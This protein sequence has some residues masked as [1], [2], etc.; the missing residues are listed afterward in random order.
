[1]TDHHSPV[2]NKL[3]LVFACLKRTMEDIFHILLDIASKKHKKHYDHNCAEKNQSPKGRSHGQKR[4]LS[5]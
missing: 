5:F 2:L 4:D 3:H 1:M